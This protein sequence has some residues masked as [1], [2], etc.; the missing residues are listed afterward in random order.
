MTTQRINSSYSAN[1]DFMPFQEMKIK[2]AWIHTPIRLNDE[3]GYFEEQFKLSQIE[4]ALGRTFT[5][6]QINQSVSNKGVIRGI[7]FTDSPQGQ[8]KYVSCPKGA[9]WD[10]VVDL[11]KESVTYGQW[12]AIEI[13]AENGLSVLIS[14]GLGHAFL[15]L[16]NGSVTH[17]LSTSEYEPSF[18][19]TINPL[20]V[21][22]AI[23]FESSGISG[24]SLSKRDLEAAQF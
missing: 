6:Q 11:R 19:R 16:E 1:L 17:Y 22:L 15:S 3:R 14:E 10:V 20:S 24:F 4:S 13:S 23:A 12:E 8:A 21:K 7:H 2:G 5:V 18:D 9:I